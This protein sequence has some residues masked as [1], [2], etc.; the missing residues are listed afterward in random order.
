MIWP[1]DFALIFKANILDLHFRHVQSPHPSCLAIDL[2]GKT[3]E[4]P[5]LVAIK[6]KNVD[7][8][9]L[10]VENGAN[11]NRIDPGT[12]SL[13]PLQEACRTSCEEMVEF[14]LLY[15]SEPNQFYLD[16]PETSPLCIACSGNNLPIVKLLLKYGAK[17]VNNVA[18]LQAIAN[19]KDHIVE[20]FLETGDNSYLLRTS[21][22]VLMCLSFWQSIY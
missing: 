21:L 16:R 19:K 11:V 12:D 1:T 17:D 8:A 9:R 3:G 13:T 4:T 6:K 20:I 2:A 5:L 18:C 15:G 22:N 7:I 10:L 14:L